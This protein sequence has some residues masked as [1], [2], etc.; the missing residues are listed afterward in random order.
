MQEE[1]VILT[2]KRIVLNALLLAFL[3]AQAP[4]QST[5]PSTPNVVDLGQGFLIDLP[6]GWVR[7]G[8]PVVSS[9]F[10][11]RSGGGISDIL[12][13]AGSR[14]T[15]LPYS[16]AETVVYGGGLLNPTQTQQRQMVDQVA[17]FYTTAFNPPSKADRPPAF[18]SAKVSPVN[19]DPTSGRYSFTVVAKYDL[20]GDFVIEVSGAFGP[21]VFLVNAIWTDADYHQD[22]AAMIL[23]MRDSVRLGSLPTKAAQAGAAVKRTAQIAVAAVIIALIVIQAMILLK[24]RRERRAEELRLLATFDSPPRQ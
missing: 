20:V 1:I 18:K 6:P 22:H 21:R 8:G 14:P 16:V 24:S 12:H 15:D 5:K 2:R 7:T 3:V 13:P 11:P 23:A 17:N 4:A 19:F 9:A 10:T